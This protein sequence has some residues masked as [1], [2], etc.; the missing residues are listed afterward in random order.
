MAQ[1]RFIYPRIIAKRTVMNESAFQKILYI[2][3]AFKDSTILKIAK[4]HP[5]KSD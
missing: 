5:R 2:A 1:L 4:L 3:D